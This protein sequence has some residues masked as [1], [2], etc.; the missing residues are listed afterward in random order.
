[1]EKLEN[2]KLNE[3]LLIGEPKHWN[4][5]ASIALFDTLDNKQWRDLQSRVYVKMWYGRS[6]Q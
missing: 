6:R 4:G 5:T 1:M 3:S 2:C